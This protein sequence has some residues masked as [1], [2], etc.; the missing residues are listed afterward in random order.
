M[1]K[2]ID[3]TLGVIVGGI[4]WFFLE[5]IFSFIPII[6]WIVAAIIAGYIAGRLG[7]NIAAVILA[8]ISPVATFLLVFFLMEYLIAYIPFLAGLLSFISAS[9]GLIEAIV[10]IINLVFVG[11]GGAIGSRTYKRIKGNNMTGMNKKQKR[12]YQDNNRSPNPRRD[13][14]GFPN[15]AQNSKIGGSL[16]NKLSELSDLDKLIVE[17]QK[18]GLT[19]E[20][21]GKI[22]G[23][24]TLVVQNRLI[25]LIEQGFIKRIGLNPLEILILQKVKTGIDANEIAKETGTSPETINSEITRLKANGMLDENL[26]MTSLGYSTLAMYIK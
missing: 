8:V 5:I 3:I 7:G 1:G 13:T 17:K 26:K 4:A 9:V 20:E 23:M 12:A 6:G 11:I 2:A 19:P 16:D 10:A 21:I 22:V 25:S 14:A 24:D 18:Y 15:S